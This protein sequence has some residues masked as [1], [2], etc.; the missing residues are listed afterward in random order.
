[1]PPMISAPIRVLIADDHAVVR[2]GLRAL[3]EAQPG[4]VVVGEADGGEEACRLA[5]ELQ[6]DVL[7]LDV[8]MPNGGGAEAA[9]RIAGELPHVKVLVLTMHEERGYVARLLSAGAAGYALKRS[10]ATELLRAIRTVHLGER[11]VDPALAGT[12]LT[13]SASRLRGGHQGQKNGDSH[14]TPR[15]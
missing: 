7:L 5:R 11:Y 15:E 14:L 1:M 6:P 12:L 8:S 3:M 9:E 4:I 10:A 13:E 2:Q